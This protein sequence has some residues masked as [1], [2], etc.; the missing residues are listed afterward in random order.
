MCYDRETVCSYVTYACQSESTLYS[1]LSV[2]ELL[3]W[4]RCNIWSLSDCNEIRTHSHLVCKQIFNYLAKLAK[5]V[6]GSNPVADRETICKNKWCFKI[7]DIFYEYSLIFC[8]LHFYFLF[9]KYKF[10]KFVS[11][12]NIGCFFQMLSWH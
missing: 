1:C 3:A 4:N 11:V 12:S 6:V 10:Y 8:Q 9:L 5:V 2:K 7:I